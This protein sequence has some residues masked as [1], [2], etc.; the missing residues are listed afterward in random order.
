MV[1]LWFRAPAAA[2]GINAQLVQLCE[3]ES[4]TDCFLGV[5]VTVIDASGWKIVVG[6]WSRRL[7]IGI[8]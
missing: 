2:S 4:K 8:N 7:M 5:G 6:E 3:S 1:S